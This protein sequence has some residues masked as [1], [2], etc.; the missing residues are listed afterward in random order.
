MERHKCL[1]R[2]S[3]FLP[4]QLYTWTTAFSAEEETPGT[5]EYSGEVM[6]GQNEKVTIC[7]PGR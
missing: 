1:F 6:W 5:G 3:S 2:T 4:G 7:Q